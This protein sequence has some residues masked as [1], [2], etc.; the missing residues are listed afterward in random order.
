MKDILLPV[1]LVL[2]VVAAI[3]YYVSLGSQREASARALSASAAEAAATPPAPRKKTPPARHVPKPEPVA[4][5][6]VVNPD[7][8]VEVVKTA[9]PAPKPVPI[10]TGTLNDVK[11][12][13]QATQVVDLLGE[14]KLTAVTTKK[15]ILFETYVYAHA[16]GDRVWMV[17]LRGGRVEKR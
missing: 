7:P 1:A 15:G 4:E 9:A 2:I 14:P 3:W 13:M 16:P 12:G 17:C 5:A 11:P 8:V 10:P 6:A